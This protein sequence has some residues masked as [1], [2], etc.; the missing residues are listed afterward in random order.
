[1]KTIRCDIP[2]C[3]SLNKSSLA[4]DWLT[5]AIPSKYHD[6]LEQCLRYKPF[7][8]IKGN[9]TCNDFGFNKSNIIECKDFVYET[10]E[11]TIVNEWNIT[12]DLNKWK[13]T[14]VGTINN[15]GQFLCLPITGYVSD[16]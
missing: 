9:S 10:S 11:E 14:L 1:M 16:K 4:S 6:T 3:D 15:I 13:L 7:L 5:H 12:C 2:E 8:D